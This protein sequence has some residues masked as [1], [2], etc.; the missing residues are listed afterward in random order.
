[1]RDLLSKYF[2]SSNRSLVQR[3]QP[4]LDLLDAKGCSPQDFVLELVSRIGPYPILILKCWSLVTA[5]PALYYERKKLKLLDPFIQVVDALF[6][7]FQSADLGP[8]SVI[9]NVNRQD[10]LRRVLR[11]VRFPL[12]RWHEMGIV[13]SGT[14]TERARGREH[15]KH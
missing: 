13:E 11:A 5:T 3:L 6:K 9:S 12:D 4:A 1:M 8:I 7:H 2:E 14:R 10:V 15:K